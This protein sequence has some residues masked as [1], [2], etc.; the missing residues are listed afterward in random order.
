MLREGLFA[1]GL[2]LYPATQLRIGGLPIGPGEACLFGWIGLTSL[3]RLLV[4]RSVGPVVF[5]VA[6]FWFI[7]ALSLS[8]GMV[9]GLLVEPFHDLPSI[10]HDVV[11][12]SLLI[13]ISILLALDLD[14]PVR[15]LRTAR[16]VVFCGV[17]VLTVQLADGFGVSVVPGTDPWFFDR[18]RG[19]SLDPN[20]LGLMCATLTLLSIY[21]VE[22]SDR[23]GERLLA[24]GAGAMVFCV[25]L[26]T[27]S[28]SY[29]VCVSLA[30][31]ALI[32]TGAWTMLS[33][34]SANHR[35][36]DALMIFAVLALPVTALALAPF[37]R[38]MLVYAQT[39][40]T[41]V[42]EDDDQGDTRLGLWTEA[43]EKG[44]EANLV[45]FGPGAHLTSKSYKRPP[46]DKFEAHNTVLDLFTQGGVVAV[47]L[48]AWLCLSAFTRCWS[49]GL[50]SLAALAVGFTAFSMFHFVIRHPIFWFGIMLCLLETA[51]VGVAVRSDAP[52]PVGARA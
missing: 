16:L 51:R 3:E 47:L 38:T 36:R 2:V 29:V 49:A 12:Y 10:A 13:A 50:P 15:R 23:A 40:S 33:R 7:F 42:Y 11:A 37:A 39:Q 45:G 31:L 32:A 22:K 41:A 44:L 9:V 20:Q 24:T 43:I 1:L 34:P 52:H 5:R 27:K 30:A 46:P 14:D 8:L 19:W 6:S 26:L 25:G 21:L 35:L 18:F 17:A 28:D 48:F 4:P